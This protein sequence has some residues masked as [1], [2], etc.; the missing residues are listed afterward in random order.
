MVC[1]SGFMADTGLCGKPK[2]GLRRGTVDGINVIEICLPYSNY[3]CLTKRA[4]TFL[5]YSLLSINIALQEKY[6]LLFATSTPL[7]AS[8]PGVFMKVL[9]P[10][11]KFVFEVRDLWPELPK[12]MG[13]V[14]NLI[15]IGA[16]WALE[17]ISYASMNAG[18]ALS[19]GIK[20]G[21]QKMFGCRKK[22]A[23]IPNGCDLNLFKPVGKDIHQSKKNILQIPEMG[24]RCIFTGAHGVA[25]GL[26]AVLDAA[27]ILKERKRSDIHLIFIGDGRLKPHLKQRAAEEV[28]DNC[29]FLDPIPKIELA[30][31]LKNMD[32]G[33]MIL[34][35]VKAFYFGTSPNK[36]FDFI[37]SGLPVLN[38]YP[39][40]I[41]E[42]IVDN[43]CGIAVPPDNATAFAD[44]LIRMA[45]NPILRKQMSRNSR[46][47]AT[48]EFS[49]DLLA[50]RMIV[51]LEN[52]VKNKK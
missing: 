6:D 29:I 35:N 23:M 37:S 9:K 31:L 34:K 21:M 36:F 48:N 30:Q 28:L 52:V 19:P 4:F 5:K 41:A 18:V 40:W 42:V 13:V 7:T 51:F 49:R 32:V 50:D 47:Q 10:G 11:T 45:D 24:L 46:K 44:A 38:N 16:L 22:I 20:Q 3:D 43:A 12:A 17:Q 15:V 39:G 1:G 14:T 2:K 25:N 27:K 8:V 26:D 33:L